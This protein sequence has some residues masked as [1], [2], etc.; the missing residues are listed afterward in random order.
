MYGVIN[1]MVLF[2]VCVDIVCVD[3]IIWTFDNNSSAIKK[4]FRQLTSH[5]LTERLHRRDFTENKANCASWIC[6]K[7]TGTFF[8]VLFVSENSHITGF[9][10][11][12]MQLAT[13]W[14]HLMFLFS[15]WTG[16]EARSVSFSLPP[17]VP[18]KR[19]GDWLCKVSLCVKCMWTAALPQ[20]LQGMITSQGEQLSNS[21]ERLLI[22]SLSIPPLWV[23]I[24]CMLSLS[25]LLSH[26][27]VDITN[28]MCA[29]ATH[30]DANK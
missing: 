18:T 27:H 25:L 17:L 15:E 10:L 8:R 30:A 3:V 6:K 14:N 23:L 5:L 19:W 16:W 11:A 24:C 7:M 22:F 12:Q 1:L 13:E 26:T 9:A 20:A 21:M 28:T 4:A 29:C 2:Y